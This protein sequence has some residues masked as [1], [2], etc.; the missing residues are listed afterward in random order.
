MATEMYPCDRVG[1]DFIDSAVNR[2]SNSVEL[3]ITPE[4]LFEVLADASSWPKWR[5]STAPA[6][7]AIA[8]AAESAVSGGMRR[9]DTGAPPACQSRAARLSA[10]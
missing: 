4:Q 9:R 7:R 5:M 6:S 8:I 10:R 2:F 1:L 3:N